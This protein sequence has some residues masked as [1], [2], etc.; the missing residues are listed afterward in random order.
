MPATW[1]SGPFAMPHAYDQLRRNAAR[2]P[3]KASFVS[4][5]W[6]V[7]VARGLAPSVIRDRM[8]S[9]AR[10]VSELVVSGFVRSSLSSEP[11]ASAT[12]SV[13]L[14]VRPSYTSPWNANP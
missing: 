13:T 4:C 9:K 7:S 1:L 12:N 5:S 3:E 14:Q 11:P 2:P 8:N 6:Y 10:F